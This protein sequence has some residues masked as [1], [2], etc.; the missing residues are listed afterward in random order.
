MYLFSYI[1][2]TANTLPGRAGPVDKYTLSV[3]FDE[4]PS[5]ACRVLY[6][7]QKY[8]ESQSYE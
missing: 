2:S 3:A 6:K 1:P 7:S 8:A 4:A 5:L